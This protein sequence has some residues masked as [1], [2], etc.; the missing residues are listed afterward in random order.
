MNEPLTQQ[1]LNNAAGLSAIELLIVV[2]MISVLTGFAFIQI[3]RARQLMTRANAAHQLAAY[4]EKARLDSVRRR[5]STTPQMAQ[6][7]ILNATFYSVTVDSNGDGTLDAPQV[8]SLPTDANLQFD[9]PYPRTIYFNWRGRTVDSDG[10][11]ANPSFVNIRS[12][13][14]G[15][16]RIDLT[17]AGQPTLDGPPASTA[18]I[19]SAAPAPSFRNNTQVP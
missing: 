6:V 14:Y 11:I 16:T 10:N 4:L 2:A 15:S 12:P 19:N 7:S 1:R 5:P 18:V 3:A 13:N 8:I 17:S 9:L